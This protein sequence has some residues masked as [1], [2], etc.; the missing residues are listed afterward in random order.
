MSITTTCKE[1][2]S[3]VGHKAQDTFEYA[4]W[5]DNLPESTFGVLDRSCYGKGGATFDGHPAQES[6]P[7]VLA[8]Y[9]S[10]NF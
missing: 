7:M 3:Q 8:T 5:N 9:R 1:L 6:S 4:I 2:Q 10:K